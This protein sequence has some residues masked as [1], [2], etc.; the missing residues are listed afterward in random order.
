MTVLP[1]NTNITTNLPTE[2]T[3]KDQNETIKILGIYFNE[4]LQYANNIN[5]QITIDKME[6]DINKLSPRILSLNGKVTIANT[7]ILSKTSFLNNIFPLN[8]KTTLNI[9]KK[10]FQ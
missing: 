4:D 7:L 10:I 6:K 2:I 8:I 9:R 3:I 5:W 1:I